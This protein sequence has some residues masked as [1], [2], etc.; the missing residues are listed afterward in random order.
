MVTGSFFRAPKKCCGLDVRISHKN[1]QYISSSKLL[2]A[3][4]NLVMLSNPKF[5]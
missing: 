3:S 4:P 5:Q 2:T 1:L